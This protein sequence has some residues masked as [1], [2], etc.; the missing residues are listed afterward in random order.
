MLT[1][2]YLPIFP[3]KFFVQTDLC[4]ANNNASINK[5]HN[6]LIKQ[7]VILKKHWKC[8][9]HSLV[10][11]RSLLGENFYITMVKLCDVTSSELLITFQSTNFVR[12]CLPHLSEFQKTVM[13]FWQRVVVH[14]NIFRGNDW[15]YFF[16]LTSLSTILIAQTLGQVITTSEKDLKFIHEVPR[17]ERNFLQVKL[18]EKGLEEPGPENGSLSKAFN[19]YW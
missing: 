9:Y 16:D 2:L 15:N 14:S 1:Q 10:E 12:Q 3:R 4:E 19:Y 7:Y 5:H 8:G 13:N 6:I 17:E 18:F 11:I